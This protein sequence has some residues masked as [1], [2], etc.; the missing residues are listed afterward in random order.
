MHH[1][2]I[3]FDNIHILIHAQPPPLLPPVHELNPQRRVVE[4]RMLNDL[5]NPRYLGVPTRMRLAVPLHVQQRGLQRLVGLG[6]V[7]ILQLRVM[8]QDEAR[9]IDWKDEVEIRP[10]ESVKPEL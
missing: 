1:F 5:D 6:C 3:T 4:S 8:A 10:L 7:A 9:R 2:Y